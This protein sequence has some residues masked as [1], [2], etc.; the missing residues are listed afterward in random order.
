MKRAPIIPT[1]KDI[2]N[3]ITLLRQH[4]L[5]IISDPKYK[6]HGEELNVLKEFISGQRLSLSEVRAA[7][8]SLREKSK[9]TSS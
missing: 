6:D 7:I 4:I 3:K 2:S 1:R 9:P 8:S 5:Q